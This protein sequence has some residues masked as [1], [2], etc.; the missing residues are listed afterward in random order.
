MPNST[1]RDTIPPDPNWMVRRPSVYLFDIGL[2]PARPP[3]MPDGM[4]IFGWFA[5][6]RLVYRADKF[7]HPSETYVLEFDDE[8]GWRVANDVDLNDTS[9]LC[10][11]GVAKYESYGVFLIHKDVFGTAYAKLW[12]IVG[13][14]EDGT[15]WDMTPDGTVYHAEG[16][17]HRFPPD[18]L[19]FC[20][21]ELGVMEDPHIVTLS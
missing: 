20:M 21:V 15:C 7:G 18:V 19:G 2:N 1:G 17:T 10:R 5:P 11:E 6:L 4:P 8:E 9:N 13:Y 3:E 16:S 14:N 12:R